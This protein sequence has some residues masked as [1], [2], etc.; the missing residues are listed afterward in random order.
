MVYVGR[1]VNISVC[2]F[3]GCFASRNY[4]PWGWAGFGKS[5]LVVWPGNSEGGTVVLMSLKWHPFG[6][7]L[8]L[9]SRL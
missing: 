8:G 3:K 6:V 5:L 7:E 2:L 4:M 9:G 1:N